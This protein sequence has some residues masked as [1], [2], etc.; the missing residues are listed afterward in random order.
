MLHIHFTDADVR[1]TR[2]AAGPDP[3]WEAVL[4]LTKLRSAQLPSHHAWWRR[5]ATRVLGGGR[6]WLDVLCGLVPP[7]GNFPDFL[8]PSAGDGTHWA[9]L[10][11]TP[12]SR[13][14]DDLAAAY[15]NRAPSDWVRRLAAD[16][17]RTVLAETA[18]ALRLYTEQ[19]LAPMWDVVC[20]AVE[21]DRAWRAAALLD[22][23]VDQ[24]LA[25]LRPDIQWDGA[26]LTCP[27]P[28]PHSIELG[29]RGITLLPSYFCSA[30]P[31]TLIDGDLA[32]VLVYPV[33][34]VPGSDQMGGRLAKLLGETRSRV[35]GLLSVS[36]TTTQLAHRAGV[37]LATASE[38][39]KVLRE[40]GL[41]SSQ[42]QGQSVVH[43]LTP[44]GRTLTSAGHK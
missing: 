34:P 40:A 19:A 12:P 43:T 2:V 18:T 25:G 44:H 1:R 7:K 42:R 8:T 21:V 24:L 9:R 35:L 32:P 5:D 20:H 37:S 38:H 6:G 16:N 22:G 29:G 13:I 39:V 17:Q 31:T 11:D 3:L 27:Y 15:R 28:V 26:T 33:A 41:A 36:C 30:V 10:L 4:S 23:G 14:R